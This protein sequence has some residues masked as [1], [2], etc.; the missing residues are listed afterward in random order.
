MKMNLD[1]GFHESLSHEVKSLEGSEYKIC[2]QVT[3]LHK[4]SQNPLL[5]GDNKKELRMNC[6]QKLQT[7]EFRLWISKE[8]K[9][10]Q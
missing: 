6:N 3:L 8:D 7:S 10:V 9:G 5:G 4:Q 2:E 1:V